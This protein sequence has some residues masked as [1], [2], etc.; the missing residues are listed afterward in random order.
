MT[1]TWDIAATAFDGL[2]RSI[3]TIE[4]PEA[5]PE[6]VQKVTTLAQGFGAVGQ[7]DVDVPIGNIIRAILLW[8][9]SGFGTA[10]PAPTWGQI[11][12]LKDNMQT[13]YSA[14][15]WE[16]GR[17]VAGLRRCHYPPD[18]GHVHEFNGAAAAYDATL[19]PQTE[20]AKDEH[21]MLMDLDPTKDDLYSLETEGAGRVNVRAD[22]EVAETV[23]VLPIEKVGVAT[24][25]D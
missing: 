4:L 11:E 1:I 12:L 16:V 9:A 7:N 23:R 20:V 18:M 5:S 14:T 3:E 21:Y 6:F 10:T 13:H 22:A 19:E 8:G 2:R 25:L 24:Y 15:D 17:A